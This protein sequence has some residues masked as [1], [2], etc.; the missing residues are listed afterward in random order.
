M[1]TEIRI[2]TSDPKYKKYVCYIINE[3]TGSAKHAG[4]VKLDWNDEITD[5][6]TQIKFRHKGIA[7]ILMERVIKDFYDIELTLRVDPDEDDWESDE[8]TTKVRL[9]KFY[10]SLGFKQTKGDFM[11]RHPS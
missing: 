1:K 3:I 6:Y 9:R 10:K 7:R 5:L 8:K 2:D 11:T 4:S